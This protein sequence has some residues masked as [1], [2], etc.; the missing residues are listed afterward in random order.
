ML[1]ALGAPV[2]E[3]CTTRPQGSPCHWSCYDLSG[4]MNSPVSAKRST[5]TWLRDKATGSGF[6]FKISPSY[7]TCTSTT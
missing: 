6:N 2:S 7:C 5:H 3:T 4:L 1:R